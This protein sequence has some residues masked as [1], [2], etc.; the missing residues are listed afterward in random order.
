LAGWAWQIARGGA[1][2]PPC[3][4]NRNPSG[5]A[6]TSPARPVYLSNVER[7]FAIVGKLLFPRQ[8]DWEQRRSAK[9]FVFVVLFAL[10]LGFVLMKVIRMMNAQK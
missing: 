4:K 10:A 7:L 3:Q 2:V 9:T 1:A 6:L 5:A 8:Q